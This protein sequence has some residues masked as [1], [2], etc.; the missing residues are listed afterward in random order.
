MDLT[1]A[2]LRERAQDLAVELGLVHESRTRRRFFEAFIALR[3]AAHAEQRE[4]DATIVQ[5]IA[6][7][8]DKRATIKMDAGFHAELTPVGIAD[9]LLT[10]AM[11][12]LNNVAAAIR[13]QERER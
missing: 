6:D 11:C 8:L 9:G 3:D 12:L 1:E 4:R 10:D 13:A 2:A 7:E 5:A